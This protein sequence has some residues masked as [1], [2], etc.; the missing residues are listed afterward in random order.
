M[1]T[2]VEGRPGRLRVS[3]GG[4]FEPIAGYSRA[5]RIGD[6]VLVSGT[7]ATNGADEVVCRGDPAGQTTFILDKIAASL[8][9]LGAGSRRRRAHP[10]LSRRRKA[11][12]AGLTRARPTLWSRPPG[13]YDA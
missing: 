2:P 5:V 10:R 13:Q 6:R 4:A 8:A 12:G 1:A 11:M 7:T 9:A 3:S